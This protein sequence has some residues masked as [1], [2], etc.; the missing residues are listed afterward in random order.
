MTRKNHWVNNQTEEET[1]IGIV[2][3]R[4]NDVPGT[5][6]VTFSSKIDEIEIK[7]TA[8]SREGFATGAVVAAE[9]IVGREGCFGMSD[10]LQL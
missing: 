6:T 5:H 9:W 7:H 2:S 10:L 4:I 8:H 1:E 3:K